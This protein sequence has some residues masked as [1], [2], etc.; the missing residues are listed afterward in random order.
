MRFQDKE[1][2]VASHKKL[3]FRKSDTDLVNK[4]FNV[5]IA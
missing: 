4:L 2:D 1:I 3:D 5:R